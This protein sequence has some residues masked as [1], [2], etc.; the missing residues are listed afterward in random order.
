MTSTS[1]RPRHPR[2]Q[3]AARLGAAVVGG[4]AF[5]WG[6]IA[7]SMALLSKAGMDFHDAEFLG[8]GLGLLLWLAVLLGVV[9]GRRHPGWAWLGLVGGGAL[10]AALASFAQSTM[11]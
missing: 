6:F 7:A 8:S 4:Y 2:L 3:L 1:I 9:S 11:V 10:L 5:T